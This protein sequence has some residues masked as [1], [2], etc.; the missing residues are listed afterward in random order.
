[1]R[2]KNL[3]HKIYEQSGSGP[4][5]SVLASHEVNKDRPSGS[6]PNASGYTRSSVYTKLGRQIGTDNLAKLIGAIQRVRRQP[7]YGNVNIRA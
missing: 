1:M 6:N 7:Q 5:Q 2:F 3:L 4:A